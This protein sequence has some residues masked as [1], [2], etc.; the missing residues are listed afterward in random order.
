MSLNE[1]RISTEICVRRGSFSWQRERVNHQQMVVNMNETCL[2]TTIAQIQ[3]FLNAC[4]VIEFSL[5][6]DD[7]E[8]H[9][10]I[11]R[12]LKRLDYPRLGKAD[13]RVLLRYLRLHR[14]C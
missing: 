3:P 9:E 11:S 5:S 13:K 10:H 8:R 14:W 4:S 7:V 2:T 12:V 1:T 6:G